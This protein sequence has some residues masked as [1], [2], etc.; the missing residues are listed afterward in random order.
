MRGYNLC[1]SNKY[2]YFIHLS[3]M[4]HITKLIRFFLIFENVH[5]GNKPEILTSD[6]AS[7]HVLKV[8]GLI[9]VVDHEN[10][11]VHTLSI[12]VKPYSK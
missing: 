5:P 2:L 11:N 9:N 3:E 7:G 4:N 6:C 8:L 1:K 12:L 10:Y